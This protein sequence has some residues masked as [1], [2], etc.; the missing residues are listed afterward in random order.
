MDGIESL[1]RTL[2]AG[3]VD[4]CFANPGTSEMPFVA[5]VDQVPE[6]KCV[7]C[8]TEGVVT[9]AA[10]GYGR[11]TDRPAATLLHL[12]VGVAN[13]LSN[14]HNA[15]K[16]R[17][18]MINLVGQN[19]ARHL[20][21][22]SILDASI[23]A[24]LA[25]YSDWLRIGRHSMDLAADTAEA[26][27]EARRAPGRIASLVIQADAGWGGSPGVARIRPWSH[28]PHPAPALV[29][30]VAQRLHASKKAILLIDGQALRERG[31]VA[32]SRIAAKTGC[33]AYTPQLWARMERGAGRP[34]LPE[35]P[36][37][38]LQAQQVMVG[39]DT[40]ILVGARYPTGSFSYPEMPSSPVG[41]DVQVILLAR[42]EEDV[43]AAL[44]A[45]VDALDARA[46]ALP[47]TP[48]A[49]P[50]LPPD[51]DKLTPATMSAIMAN[52]LPEHAIVADEA[53]LASDFRAATTAA[54][55]HD[56]LR[57][58]GGAIGIVMPLALGAAIACPQRPVLAIQGDGC[59]M[60]NLQAL[61]TMARHKA[62]VTVV[63]YA[64]RQYKVLLNELTRMGVSAPQGN[65]RELLDL[66]NPPLDWVVLAKGMGVPGSQVTTNGEFFAAIAKGFS[67]P[68]PKLIE[69][70]L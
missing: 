60:Y 30:E 9:G 57:I 50:K 36:M 43:T 2:V 22:E 27:Y 18:P 23:E 65:A 58:T 55:P 63:I 21:H 67:E 48:V 16:A 35:F 1:I 47:P 54:T 7:L 59:A 29:E 32:A 61:W 44:E 12:G 56:F 25:A 52:L 69:A 20:R 51:G 33:A 41:D 38:V 26:I 42:P 62:N 10:D 39:V 70:V 37:S 24:P 40:L 15:R 45:L 17:S 53:G 66:G 6:L 64:N 34:V 31:L 5:A 14:L 68:G 13:G 8:L 46:V 19:A 28:A 49:L 11:M 3:G 4:T